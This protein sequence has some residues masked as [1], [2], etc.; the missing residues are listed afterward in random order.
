[1]PH[2]IHSVTFL[3]GERMFPGDFPEVTVQHYFGSA[4]NCKLLLLLAL[5][6]YLTKPLLPFMYLILTY[7]LIH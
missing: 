6:H 1:M 7:S 5:K 3:K 4:L 2:I